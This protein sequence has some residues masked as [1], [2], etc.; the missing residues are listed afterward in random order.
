MKKII[1]R[2]V[3]IFVVVISAL[4]VSSCEKE[5]DVDLRSVEPRLVIEGVVPEDSLATVRLTKTKDFDDNTPYQPIADATVTVTD[6]D[7]GYS[8]TLLFDAVSGYYVAPTLRGVVGRT[9][10]LKVESEGESYEATSKM[11]PLVMLDSVTMYKVPAMDYAMPQVHF[12][13]PFGEE[14]HYYRFRVYV[15]G[16]RPDK[17]DDACSA[18]HTDG[19]PFHMPIFIRSNKDDVD[20]LKKGD[21]VTVEMQC[22]DKG[23][24]KYFETLYNIDEN[25]TNPTTNIVGGALGY[26]SAY[27]S[28]KKEIIAD[29]KD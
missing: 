11:P 4:V 6:E 17:S 20:P 9:Y 5:V 2:Y 16:E 28:M 23:A 14:N 27:S 25:L 22:I 24:H 29:W 8:E 13:D 3:P 10:R 7:T 12:T 19:T 1:S 15:N 21:R 18:E 26:F